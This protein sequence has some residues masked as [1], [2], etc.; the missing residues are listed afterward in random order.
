MLGLLVLWRTL[1][2]CICSLYAG[3]LGAA[4]EWNMQPIQHVYPDRNS[5][6]PK[7]DITT[8]WQDVYCPQN[9]YGILVK[10]ILYKIINKNTFSN[11]WGLCNNN[12][13]VFVPGGGMIGVKWTSV[14]HANYCIVQYQRLTACTSQARIMGWGEGFSWEWIY[15]GEGI[16]VACYMYYVGRMQGVV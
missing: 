5:K 2:F 14:W 7:I 16:W 13:S 3:W 12:K 4:G 8:S 15:F 11:R 10:K 6:L 9:Y 1:Q